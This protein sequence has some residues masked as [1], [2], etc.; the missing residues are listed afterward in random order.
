MTKRTLTEKQRKMLAKKQV[1]LQNRIYAKI[2]E[3]NGK[4]QPHAK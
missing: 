2:R 4:S 3:M 1:Q